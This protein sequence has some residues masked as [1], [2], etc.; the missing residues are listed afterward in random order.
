MKSVALKSFSDL[1]IASFISFEQSIFNSLTI[2]FN[3]KLLLDFS[4]L[5]ALIISHIISPLFISLLKLY[6]SCFISVM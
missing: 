6:S 2:V 3:D 5:T 4:P 1:L